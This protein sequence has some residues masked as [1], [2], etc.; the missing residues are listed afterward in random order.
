MHFI[1]PFGTMISLMLSERYT[2][3]WSDECRTISTFQERKEKAKERCYIFIHPGHVM[4]KC[5]VG[6]PC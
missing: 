5:K 2:P 3:S 4:A 6:K 1:K